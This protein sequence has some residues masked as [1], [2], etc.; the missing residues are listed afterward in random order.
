V[1]EADYTFSFV[2]NGLS[3]PRIVSLLRSHRRWFRGV[4]FSLD[5]AREATHDQLRGGGSFR[6]VMRAATLCVFH[7]LPFTFNMVLTT[8]NRSE[9]DGLV[10]LGE[11][12][13]SRGVRFGHLMFTPGTNREGLDLSPVERREVERQIWRLKK[14]AS[15]YVGMAPG[16][17][18]DSP[19]FPCAPLEQEE[20][21]VDYRGN[22]TLCC[23][24]SGYGGVN[25]GDDVIGNLRDMTVAEACQRFGQR[26][27]RYLADK[28][29]RVLEGAF[30]ELDHFPCW[31]CVKYLGKV[32]REERLSWPTSLKDSD[33]AGRR[34]ID[35]VSVSQCGPA[36]ALE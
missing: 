23:H 10:R 20:F 29:A 12:L 18:S 22:V 4:T 7:D 14:D 19:F 24:L 31:Y 16:Y 26:V 1:C 25:S 27:S 35:V 13:G 33:T 9:V 5:G 21:N 15:V 28:R 8:R 3:F 32:P 36:N 2:S 34:I 6:Q 11:Q 30:G 17:Y